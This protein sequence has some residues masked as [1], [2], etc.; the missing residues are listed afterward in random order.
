MLLTGRRKVWYTI[1][2]KPTIRQKAGETDE[3]F[4]K[5]M[6]D[7]Y[8]TDTDSKIRLLEITRTDAEVENFRQELI[9][10]GAE[11]AGAQEMYKNTTHCQRWGRR[12]EYASIC[13]HYD[14]TQN[15]I[16]FHHWEADR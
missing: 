13:L 15:Y 3:E 6:E 5:R 1:C 11:I 10:I 4:A 14:P 9:S 8:E 2:R 12:C 16:G 7:W